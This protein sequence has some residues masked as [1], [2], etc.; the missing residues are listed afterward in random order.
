ML[1]N[2]LLLNLAASLG[3]SAIGAVGNG[4]SN[5]F[6]GLTNNKE[7]GNF[8]DFLNSLGEGELAN[9]IPQEILDLV[10]PEQVES[11]ISE[12]L[13]NKL[14]GDELSTSSQ[15]VITQILGGEVTKTN[16]GEN[17]V[18]IN[19]NVNQVND[20]V[21]A[22]T[23]S[24]KNPLAGKTIINEDVVLET[25]SL[26]TQEEIIKVDEKLI[27]PLSKNIGQKEDE[28]ILGKDNL[29]NMVKETKDNF[30]TKNNE[31]LGL[32]NQTIAGQAKTNSNGQ[33]NLASMKLVDATQDKVAQDNINNALPNKYDPDQFAKQDQFAR[34]ATNSRPTTQSQTTQAQSDGSY[35]VVNFTKTSDGI[36]LKLEPVSMGKLQIKFEVNA[37]GKMN[38]AIY[39]E[40]SDTLNI[41]RNDSSSI[42]K[43]LEE[44]GIK[45]DSNSLSF[46]LQQQGSDKDT[47]NRFSFGQGRDIAFNIEQELNDNVKDISISN[48]GA[49][50]KDLT[51]VGML[52][53]VV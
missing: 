31:V 22:N 39:A 51:G 28:R 16:K 42:Q 37:E 1:T 41:L 18:S 48:T 26:N 14:S 6:N 49:L 19:Q 20:A 36:E 35:R 24:S 45:A 38:L 33:E 34:E 13:Q 3:G 27:S 15:E 5:A 4:V 8:A 11:E 25:K 32:Q 2:S 30:S 29:Q 46:N 47:E 10:N 53:L 40:K 21:A 7:Q 44:N 23:D 50:Y 17:N 43:I 52:N 9:S 12:F